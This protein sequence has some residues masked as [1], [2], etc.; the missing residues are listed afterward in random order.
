[1][2]IS[3]KSFRYSRARSNLR[4]IEWKKGKKKKL[5]GTPP[6]VRVKREKS[7]DYA[8]A[9]VYLFFGIFIL[10]FL[11][12]VVN[13]GFAFAIAFG[14]YIGVAIMYFFDD[15]SFF[16]F[17][18]LLSANKVLVRIFIQSQFIG[19]FNKRVFFHKIM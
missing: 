6:V 13:D 8:K 19:V 16:G 4:D 5:K 7:I 14:A 11:L 1:M 12:T 15:V 9:L 17:S 3:R 2:L 10:F 18:I